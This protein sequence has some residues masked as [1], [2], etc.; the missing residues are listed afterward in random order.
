MRL[1]ALNHS[2]TYLSALF[3]D[4]LDPYF[5][6]VADRD[7]LAGVLDKAVCHL[8]NVDKPVLL[9]ANIDER[10]EVNDVAD[11]PRKFHSNGQI[12]ERFHRAAEYNR[13]RVGANITSRLL[14]FGNDVADCRQSRAKFGGKRRR[15]ADVF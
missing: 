7:D 13:R 12:V 4:A 6:C 2:E 1:F 3:V 15:I 5:H 8:G 14:K 9:H 11:G 10:A